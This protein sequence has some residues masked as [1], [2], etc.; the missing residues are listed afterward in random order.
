MLFL[1]YDVLKLSDRL[2]QFETFSSSVKHKVF[3]IYIDS[4]QN[5][6][7]YKKV[8]VFFYFEM[9]FFVEFSFQ[10]MILLKEIHF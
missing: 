7:H 3:H 2:Q 5:L 9:E 6:K 1:Y 10:Y 8:S 4:I